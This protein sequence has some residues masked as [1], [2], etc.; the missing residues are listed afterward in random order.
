MT[1]GGQN[2]RILGVNL[3]RTSDGV[4]LDDGAA[5]LLEDGVCTVAIA[6]E[7][8]TRVKH[9]GGIARSAHYCL[10]SRGLEISQIDQIAISVCCDGVPDL[11]DALA[12]LRQ[13]GIDAEVRQLVIVPSHHLSHA[14]SAYHPSGFEDAIVIVADNEGSIIGERTHPRYWHNRLERTSVYQGRGGALHLL[15]RYG[16]Q[17][18]ELSLG[19]AYNHVTKWLGFN[20]YHD[21]G[22]VMALAAY[23]SGKFQ[24][25]QIFS[26]LADGLNCLIKPVSAE[27]C[28]G[29]A[30]AAPGQPDAFD[31]EAAR[32]LQGEA[33]RDLI[34]AQ[35]G[36]DVG[37]A[38]SSCTVPDK[39]QQEVAWLIQ[40]ELE[41]ALIQIVKIAVEQ[42]GVR[43]VCLA[44]GV[45]LNCVANTLVA[46]LPEVD[47]LFIQP[48]A[49]DVGQSLGNALWAYHQTPEP[50]PWTMRSCSLGRT[51]NHADIAEAIVSAIESGLHVEE[52]A[53]MAFTAATLIAQGAIIGWF[54]TGSEFGL[55]GLGRRSV[56][57]DPRTI[58]TKVR[59]DTVIKRR[60]LFRPYAPSVLAEELTAWFDIDEQFAHSAMQPMTCMFVAPAIRENKQQLVPAV[61]FVDGSARLQAV[62]VAENPRYHALIQAF[63]TLTGVPLV[64]NTSFNAGGDPVVETPSDALSSMTKMSLDAL[65]IG[66]FLIR[67]NR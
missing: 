42:T 32:F 41:R 24:G 40:H 53:D 65:V 50:R 61:T 55:R 15:A 6:E 7:R 10:E 38:R 14:A 34:R 3:T 30:L 20:S 46:Q 12:W 31:I 60:E 4:C 1:I 49:S 39:D 57:G 9:A 52:P 56:L 25:V 21:A 47:E 13:E 33:V 22:K 5:A 35:V 51:Y 27:S 43:N 23:G 19:S 63:H 62:T 67:P 66:N 37:P 8:L 36:N 17:P 2:V 64:L 45:A 54:D 26:E 59:L 16:D 18:G 48:A 58:D 11:A 28:E 44:G 29:V